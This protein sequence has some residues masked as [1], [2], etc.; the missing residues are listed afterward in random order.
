MR[1]YV[2]WATGI[3]EWRAGEFVTARAAVRGALELQPEFQD[4][5]CAGVTI[6]LL[7][8][9]DAAEGEFERAAQLVGAARAVWA[10][11]GTEIAS[12]GVHLHADSV[13]AA[14]R[15]PR[16]PGRAALRRDPR[17]RPA[18]CRSTRPSRSR[19]TRRLPAAPAADEPS[20]LTAREQEIAALIAEGL[21]NKAIATSLVV[22]P[23]TVDGHL[24]R[25]FRKLDL[26]S[27]AQLAAWVTAARWLTPGGV[28]R[29]GDPPLEPPGPRCDASHIKSD[30]HRFGRRRPRGENPCHCLRTPR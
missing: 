15:D 1:A 30:V 17:A 14:A 25:I 8:W 27:R 29:W 24:E 12:F 26:T 5:I 20:P 18:G 22:S 13:A 3:T 28:T 7:G 10:D 16:A 6:E 23:R 2:M 11:V 21:S 9:I 4:R 19:S